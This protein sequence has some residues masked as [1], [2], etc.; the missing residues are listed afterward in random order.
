MR[1]KKTERA[2]FTFAIDHLHTITVIHTI[3]VLAL[4]CVSGWTGLARDL[5]FCVL[6][7]TN[8]TLTTVFGRC[9]Q[10][11]PGG[12]SNFVIKENYNTGLSA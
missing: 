2:L 9:V 8:I 10:E 11:K 12:T 3:G 7:T 1:L 6:I 4:C 5:A